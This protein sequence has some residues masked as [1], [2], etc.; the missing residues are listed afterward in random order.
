MELVEESLLTSNLKQ[1]GSWSEGGSATAEAELV[2]ES[3]SVSVATPATS[4]G[5]ESVRPWPLILAI[6]TFAVDM[7][8][9][10][11]ST[12]LAKSIAH[13]VGWDSGKPLVLEWPI[14][15]TTAVW[16]VVFAIYGLYDLRRPT[17]ATAELQ[18]LFNAILM[19]VLLIGSIAFALVQRPFRSP[20][21]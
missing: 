15:L 14:F 5:K 19:S 3:Q 12:Y 16:P 6:V 21:P 10:L 1:E 20:A 7:V 2:G 11:I 17:H 13:G 18:R 8:A 4:P 9:V